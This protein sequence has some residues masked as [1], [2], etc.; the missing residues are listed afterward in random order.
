MSEQRLSR[1]VI[2]TNPQGLHARPA[3]MFAK[4]SNQFESKIH[5]VNND[6]RVDG[7]SILEILTLAAMAGTELSIE[8]T[9]HDAQEALDALVKLIEKN[10]AEDEK[11]DE[12]QAR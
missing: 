11:S 10:F 3:D 1:R 6:T 2:L 8:A 4:L 9:G 7:K 12:K 5:L